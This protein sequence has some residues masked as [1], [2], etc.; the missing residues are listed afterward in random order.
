LIASSSGWSS[1]QVSWFASAR[2]DFA[3]G[4]VQYPVAQWAKGSADSYTLTQQIS[5]YLPSANYK[6]AAFISGFSTSAKQFQISI[7]QKN[8]DQNSRKL[9]VVFYSNAVPQ[10]AAITIS[11]IIYPEVHSVFE[12]SYEV[13]PLGDTGAYQISGP[14]SFGSV[15]Q[16]N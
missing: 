4:N 14:V 2:E 5:K 9:T 12:L 16:Y 8:Y 10:P 11:Y 3:V 15:I 7:N 6:V 13:R 1:I